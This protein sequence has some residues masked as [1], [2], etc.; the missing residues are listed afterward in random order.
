MRTSY[1]SAMFLGIAL[2]GCRAGPVNEPDPG[3]PKIDMGGCERTAVIDDS[4]DNDHRTLDHEGRG[5]YAY[6]FLDTVGS[7]VEPLAGRL[8]GTFAQS[9]GGAN[10]SMYA[11]R[12]QGS[13]VDGPIVFAGLGMNFTDPRNRT[14]LTRSRGSRSSLDTARVR[15]HRCG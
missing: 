6:T 12:F 13:L 11:A 7:T 14:T 15:S 1:A 3:A 5:G 2:A 9:E 4:E 8:G 10:G